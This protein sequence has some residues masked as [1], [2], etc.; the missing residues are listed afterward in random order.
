MDSPGQK[1]FQQFYDLTHETVAIHHI[2]LFFF[3]HVSVCL[4]RPAFIVNLVVLEDVDGE[5]PPLNTAVP[6]VK[7]TFLNWN[8]VHIGEEPRG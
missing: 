4:A 3:I 7:D 6:L 2:Y 8:G 1:Y 5:S